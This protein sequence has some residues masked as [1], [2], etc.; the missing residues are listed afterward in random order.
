MQM[1]NSAPREAMLRPHFEDEI[2]RAV[3]HALNEPGGGTVLQMGA[4]EGIS[5]EDNSSVGWIDLSGGLNRAVRG[6]G[7][8]HQ[9]QRAAP[10]Q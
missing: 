4:A 8:G 3:L 1:G 7:R 9:Q 6:G 5:Q 10:F 2:L